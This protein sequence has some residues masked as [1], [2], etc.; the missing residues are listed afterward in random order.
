MRNGSNQEIPRWARVGWWV[1]LFV[2]CL[3][4]WFGPVDFHSVADAQI[5]DGGLQRKQQLDEIKMTNQYLSEIKQ[6]LKSGT[7]NV[8]VQGADNK[9]DAASPRVPGSP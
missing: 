2:T 9:A 1:F 5:P 6:L 8:R 3:R 7:I 4:V